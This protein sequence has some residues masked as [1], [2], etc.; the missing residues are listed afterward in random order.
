MGGTAIFVPYFGPIYPHK[1]PPAAP[2]GWGGR[3]IFGAN[4]LESL[5]ERAGTAIEIG[6]FLLGPWRD[7][8]ASNGRI[9]SISSAR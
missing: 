9:C 5:M 6:V 2:G 8:Q 4:R 1:T 3:G 7:G